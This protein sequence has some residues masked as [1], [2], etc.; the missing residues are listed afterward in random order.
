MSLLGKQEFTSKLA[1]NIKKAR[2]A[3]GMSQEALAYEAK[4]YRTYV[5]HIETGTYSPSAYTVYK[6]SEALKTPIYELF[7]FK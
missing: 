2:K 5:G 7:K 6:I 3:K 1:G 4:L